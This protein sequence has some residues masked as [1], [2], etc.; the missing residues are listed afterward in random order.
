MEPVFL[1]IYDLG[2]SSLVQSVNGVLRPFGSGAYHVGVEVY[3]EEWSFA[4]MSEAEAR[5]RAALMLKSG[6]SSCA[7]RT[8]QGHTYRETALMGYTSMSK[9]EVLK[10]TDRLGKEWTGD[11]YCILT[12]NC[13]HFCDAFCRELGPGPILQMLMSLAAFGCS[14]SL[15]MQP[16]L[17]SST[18]R[19]HELNE[20]SSVKSLFFLNRE[21]LC[22]I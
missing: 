21:N 22:S 5:M 13:T 12:R 1:H 9:E 8:A 10:L 4:C 3:G 2:S 19:M 15:L 11:S 16:S 17:S 6:V 18:A 20:H 14:A 7:P